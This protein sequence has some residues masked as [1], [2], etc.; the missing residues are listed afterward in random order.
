MWPAPTSHLPLGFQGPLT[1]SLVWWLWLL[2]SFHLLQ[3][4]IPMMIS[5]GKATKMVWIL[6]LCLSVSLNLMMLLL[7]TCLPI[8]P[9]W[10]LLYLPFTILGGTFIHLRTNLLGGLLFGPVLRIA[11]LCCLQ[12]LSFFAFSCSPPFHAHKLVVLLL[13]ILRPHTIWSRM[14]LPSFLQ[15]GQESQHPH[16]WQLFCSGSWLRFSRLCSNCQHILV[17]NVLH[18][19]DLVIPLY[20]L[21]PYLQQHGCGFFDTFVGGFLVHFRHLSCWSILRCIATLQRSLSGQWFCLLHSIMCSH[22]ALQRFIFMKP[23]HLPLPSHPCQLLLRTR[24]L[25]LSL[26]PPSLPTHL[27]MF[28]TLTCLHLP[29]RFLH[30]SFLLLSHLQSHSTVRAASI[31]SFG[32][33]RPLFAC[34]RSTRASFCICTSRHE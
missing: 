32:H 33:L 27:L 13:L 15:D 21:R 16:W 7:F 5:V 18:I 20:S 2:Q 17:R 6:V 28:T 25:S 19:S 14:L 3:N 29:S 34:L 9:A 30:F 10:W 24:S 31:I 4:M 11:F 1:H 8:I 12:S 26:M 23:S 22:D